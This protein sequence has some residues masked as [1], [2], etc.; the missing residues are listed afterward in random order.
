[1]V[2]ALDAV[3]IPSIVKTS[4][5]SSCRQQ[6]VVSAEEMGWRKRKH[7]SRMSLLGLLGLVLCVFYLL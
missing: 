1:M 6:Q 3:L 7:L 2:Q 5:R 4:R